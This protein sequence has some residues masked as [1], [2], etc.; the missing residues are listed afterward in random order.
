MKKFLSAA[1]AVGALFGASAAVSTAHADVAYS[2]NIALATDYAFRGI[3][4]TDENPAVQGGFDVTMGQ[5][6]AG[7]WASN[8]N[9]GS[10]GANAEIDLYAGFKPTLGPVA[11]DIGAIGYFYPAAAD[12]APA[13]ELDFYEL[14]VKPSISPM[15]G[16]T[17]GAALYYSP[18][19]QTEVG[20]TFYYEA[21]AAFA[22]SDL[23]SVSG[24]VGHQTE[25]DVAGFFGGED[26]YTTWNVGG[27]LSVKGFGLD[28]RYVG[29]D[30]DN[31][32]AFDDR[33]IFSI[34]RA[35]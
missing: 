26:S 24:A 19:F 33:V 15:E 3:S 8:I 9:F 17:L 7:T 31:V 2:G 16:L 34:K 18:E 22:V 13:G 20:D 5:F 28:L 25:T 23:V 11:L 4:Q 30:V 10:G 29:T 6:Y 27:T 12:D 1:A 32:A 21:N 35:L 14:Y